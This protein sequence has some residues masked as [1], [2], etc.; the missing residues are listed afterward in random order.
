MRTSLNYN[1]TVNGPSLLLAA[2]LAPLAPLGEPAPDERVERHLAAMGTWL[3]LVCEAEDR[4]TALAA[5]EAAAR[6]IEAV[7]NRLSTWRDDSELA[8]FNRHPVGESFAMSPELAADLLFARELVRETR[9]AFDPAIGALVG[10]WGLRQGGR[11]PA[12]TELEAALAASGFAHLHFAEQRA[13]RLHAGVTLE[14]GGF[15]KGL[16]LDHAVEAARA[17][18]ARAGHVDLGGQIAMLGKTETSFAIAHPEQRDAT[19]LSVTIDGGSLATSGN[20]ERGIVVQGVRR[21]HLLDPRTGRPA[22][23]FGSVTVWSSSAARADALSTALFVMGP[24]KAI[25]FAKQADDCEIVCLVM[26]EDQIQVHA[27]PGL[28]ERIQIE[29]PAAVL[30]AVGGDEDA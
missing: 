7:E 16:A 14:E 23:D 19:C 30:V 13:Q 28:A 27:T 20:S 3:E 25:A 18:G 24:Q 26:Q 1:G 6:A 22:P 12:A 5:S 9:G 4:S 11:Q 29:N 21:S 17:T 2:A 15:G 10:A 8:R